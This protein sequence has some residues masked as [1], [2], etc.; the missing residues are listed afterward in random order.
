MDV[1]IFLFKATQVLVILGGLNLGLAGLLG[2]DVL[3]KV[4]GENNI[5]VRIL[6]IFAGLS[7]IYLILVLGGLITIPPTQG[8]TIQ[9][10]TN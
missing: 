5:L 4:L 6:Y 8:L 2:F 9:F 3:T 1:N 10:K 7:G